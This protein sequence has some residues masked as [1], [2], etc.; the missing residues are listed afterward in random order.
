MTAQTYLL[1]E[2]VDLATVGSIHADL[3]GRRG[4][5]L[6]VDASAVRRIGG[7]G[8]QV[9]LAADVAWETD[10]RRFRTISRSAVFDEALRLTGCFLPDGLQ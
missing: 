9:L 1:P 2:V 3:L 8:I 7:L 10:G 5:D 4:K 6:D